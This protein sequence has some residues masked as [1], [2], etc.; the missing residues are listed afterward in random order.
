MGRRKQRKNYIDLKAEMINHES[1]Y[2]FM[3]RIEEKYPYKS[4]ES[5][6]N[7]FNGDD[8]E[9]YLD[10]RYG[11]SYIHEEIRKYIFISR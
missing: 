5:L 9:E 8:L 2:R 10:R 7:D 1:I 4:D 11:T 3:D 6:F